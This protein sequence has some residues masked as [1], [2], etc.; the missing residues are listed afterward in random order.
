VSEI[1]G[2]N[3]LLNADGSSG[4]VGATVTP[5]VGDAV[6]AP[7]EPVT[8]DFAIGLQT[9]ERFTFLVDLFGEPVP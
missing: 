5:N 1:S 9:L 4:G 7:G 2:G 8:V 3:L 6:L